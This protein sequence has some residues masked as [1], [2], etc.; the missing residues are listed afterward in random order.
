MMPT[1]DMR[2]GDCLHPETGMAILA[3]KS[4]DHV[5]TD[6]AVG[7]AAEHLVCADL[8]LGGYRAF[9]ADQ[10]CPY[11]VAVDVGGRLVRIQVKATRCPRQLRGRNKTMPY[12]WNVRRAG[13]KGRRVYADGEFDLL[14]LVAIDVRR[15]AYLPPS[16]HR[17]T[18][19]IRA[20]ENAGP[21]WERGA[22]GR[23]FDQFPFFAA[24]G[25]L[26]R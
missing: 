15:I 16:Q 6:L 17:Q 19:A 24:I 26:S 4:V 1:Y 10:V 22:A 9:L 12:M 7:T 23:T 21:T 2:L 13:K 8:L 25:E 20:H 5:I 14:A 11:D 3:D 18:I